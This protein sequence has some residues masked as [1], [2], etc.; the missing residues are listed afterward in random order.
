MLP[1]IESVKTHTTLT[2]IVINLYAYFIISSIKGDELT[3]WIPKL[4]KSAIP[5]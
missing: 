1:L 2:I 5:C 3:K 4:R